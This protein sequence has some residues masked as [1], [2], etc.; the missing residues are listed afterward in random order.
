MIP[1]ISPESFST[2]SLYNNHSVNIVIIVLPSSSLCPVREE[3]ETKKVKTKQNKKYPKLVLYSRNKLKPTFVNYCYRIVESIYVY[4]WYMKQ[5]NWLNVT[6]SRSKIRWFVDVIV[7]N[8][9][10][11]FIS[12]QSKFRWPR[13]KDFVN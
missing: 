1:T 9:P 8:L 7:L 3:R 11:I 13:S 10:S 6:G 5:N 2:K 4:D 12:K